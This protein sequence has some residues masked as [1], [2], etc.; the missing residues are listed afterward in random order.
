MYGGIYGHGSNLMP[1][2]PSNRDIIKRCNS[3][4]LSSLIQITPPKWLLITIERWP[5]LRGITACFYCT[6]NT[7]RSLIS[8][9]YSH[10][11]FR[12]RK[13]SLDK[14]VELV[15][16]FMMF[17]ATLNNISVISW[18]RNQNT[19]RNTPTCRKS[20]TNFIT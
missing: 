9:L 18:R 16:G 20:L 5:Y 14:W 3:T 6:F 7:F 12:C 13:I 19:R 1:K 15:F 10:Q 4:K 8:T 2:M 17:N 11:F